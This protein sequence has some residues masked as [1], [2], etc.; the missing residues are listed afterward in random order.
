[1]TEINID[2]NKLQSFV[3]RIERL[4][5]DK[6]AVNADLK[7]LYK[8]ARDTGFPTTPLKKFIKQ[9]KIE[10]SK[11]ELNKQEEDNYWFE[12]FKNALT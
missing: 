5:A 4:E 7:E 12:S 2:T 6:Q 1:M 9:R 10:A 3:A 11:K 8:E